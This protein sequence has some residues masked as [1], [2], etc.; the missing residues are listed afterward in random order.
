MFIVL[1]NVVV[2][3][4]LIG[5]ASILTVI[6]I[7]LI[8]ISLVRGHKAK[9]VGKK[10]VPVGL[11]I[12]LTMILL[13]WALIAYF[14]ISVKIHENSPNYMSLSSVRDSAYEAVADGDAEA[15]YGLFA[16]SVIEDTGMTVEDVEA[17]L[18]SIGDI[19]GEYREDSGYHADHYLVPGGGNK[20]PESE[21]QLFYNFIMYD[22]GG[23]DDSIY[24]AAV[25]EDTEDVDELG[26]HLV[27]YD[28]E[29]IGRPETWT[30]YRTEEVEQ[31]AQRLIEEY[32]EG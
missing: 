14:I 26:L 22:I 17:F 23:T 12:G 32:G 10:H 31:E 2:I 16:P 13:P 15:L 9:K 28:D 29:I 11:I 3:A 7:A 25:C 1:L 27:A 4:I 8:I 30:S 19:D 21:T 5:I 24:F 6:A 20:R 18:D